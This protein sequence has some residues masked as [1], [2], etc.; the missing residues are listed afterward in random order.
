M[1]LSSCEPLKFNSYKMDLISHYKM[2]LISNT[3]S[4]IRTDAYKFNAQ[5]LS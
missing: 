4:L 5:L 3:I 1:L 2:D